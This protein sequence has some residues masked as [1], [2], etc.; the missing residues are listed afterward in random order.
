[1]TD[2]AIAWKSS[3]M[4]RPDPVREESKCHFCFSHPV[5]GTEGD[6]IGSYFNLC[7]QEICM[8]TCSL[9]LENKT[10]KKPN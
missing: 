1:M 7:E 10:N 9:Y 2:I 3:L 6:P 4:K 5:K 8:H